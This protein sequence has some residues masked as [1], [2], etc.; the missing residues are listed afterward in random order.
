M[1]QAKN[2]QQSSVLV[3]L[4]GVV[5]PAVPLS[6][7]DFKLETSLHFTILILACRL[8]PPTKKS[9][10]PPNIP[11]ATVAAPTC[12]DHVA[13]V[14]EVGAAA[15]SSHVNAIH[16]AAAV[17]ACRTVF[18]RVGVCGVVRTAAIVQEG[19]ATT[20]APLEVARCAVLGHVPACRGP[21][22]CL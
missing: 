21:M 12:K 22:E 17:R 18:Q 10:Q 11:S 3:Y 4:E 2:I 7:D 8:A 9:Q 6:K 16:S 14:A 19:A 13:A 20:L 1:E 15:A 5:L